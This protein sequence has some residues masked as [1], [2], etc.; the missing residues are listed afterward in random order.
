MKGSR[1]EEDRLYK[2]SSPEAAE[3]RVDLLSRGITLVELNEHG[4]DKHGIS[5]SPIYLA[6][7]VTGTTLLCTRYSL[8][9][10]VRGSVAG[11]TRGTRRAGHFSS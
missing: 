8:R 9:G 3:L 2:A 1:L 5:R 10:A 6:W 11:S 7:W 4:K